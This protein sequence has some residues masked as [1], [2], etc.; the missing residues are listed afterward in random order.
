MAMLLM[1]SETARERWIV[2]VNVYPDRCGLVFC[3]EIIGLALAD[4]STKVCLY[5][6]MRGLRFAIKTLLNV[7]KALLNWKKRKKQRRA[8][9]VLS[10]F[11]GRFLY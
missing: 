7:L 5:G 9:A 8:G 11:D 10:L 1:R 4:T 6:A 3:K 2:T